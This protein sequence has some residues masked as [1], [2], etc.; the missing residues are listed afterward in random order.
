[1]KSSSYICNPNLDAVRAFTRAFYDSG[2]PTERQ[3]III[4]VTCKTCFLK[5]GFKSPSLS[6]SRAAKADWYS[7]SSV[8]VNNPINFSENARGGWREGGGGGVDTDKALID[9]ILFHKN[10]TF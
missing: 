5:N 1:M 3:V 4:S 10:Q 8:E 7:K 9:R 2:S 6:S